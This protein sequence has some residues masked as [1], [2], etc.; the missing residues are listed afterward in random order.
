MNDNT[1]TFYVFCPYVRFVLVFALHLLQFASMFGKLKNFAIKK[2]LQ[3]Q[4]KNVPAEQRELIMTL[5]EKDPALFEKIAKE[6]QAEMKTNGNNQ[7]Q[8]AMKVLPR[9]QNEILGVMSPEMKAKMMSMAQG[10]QGKF[11]PNGTIRR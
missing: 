9:Y 6:L 8:A 5:V 7:M 10:V 3:S 1:T 4:L 2:L 11:N